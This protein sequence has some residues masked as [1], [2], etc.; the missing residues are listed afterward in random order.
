MDSPPTRGRGEDGTVS[1]PIDQR[2]AESAPVPPESRHFTLWAVF[3]R[4]PAPRAR[5]RGRARRGRRRRRTR[6]HGPR[7]VRRLGAPRRRRRARVAHRRLRRRPAVGAAVPA[8]LARA[9]LAPADLEQPRRPPRRGV[10]P[11]PRA[12]VRARPRATGVGHGLPLRAQLRVVRAARRRAR[13]RCSPTTGARAASTRRCSPTPS[14]SFAL[15]DYEWI[16]ALEADDVTDLVDLM[17]HLRATEARRHVREEVPFFTGRR[18][19]AS[20][21]AEVLS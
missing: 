6:F 5:R 9:E 12:R 2:P 21:L 7:S 3:R 15:G 13:A 18:I 4:D 20:E 10:Q 19:D 1:D 17:R 16:L 8:A 14:P 11:R